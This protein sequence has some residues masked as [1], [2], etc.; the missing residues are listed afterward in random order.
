MIDVE[1]TNGRARGRRAPALRQFTFESSGV[2]VG[3]RRM[4]QATRADIAAAVAAEWRDAPEGDPR[5][6]PQPPV[7]TPPASQPGVQVDVAVLEPNR[8]DPDYIAAHQRWQ[9]AIEGAIAMRWMTYAVLVCVE[10]EPDPDEV[11]RIRTG[12]RVA[13]LDLD[14]DPELSQAERD[15]LLYFM[16]YVFD[17]APPAEIGAFYRALTLHNIPSETEVS[18]ALEQFRPDVGGAAAGDG[19]AAPAAE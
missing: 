11:A 18:D 10:Y 3:L 7:P 12:A 5:R 13:Q 17:V 8:A 16:R 9:A 2:T 1:R 6:E 19:G 15:K 14:E 4:G